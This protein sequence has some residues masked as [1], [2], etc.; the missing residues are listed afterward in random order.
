MSY[1]LH[2]KAFSRK[3]ELGGGFRGV[4]TDNRDKQRY[5]SEVLQTYEEARFFVQDTAHK[6]MKG[7]VYRRCAVNAGTAGKRYEA[8]IYGY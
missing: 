1:T 8:F 6:L 3:P 4:V 5:E 7:Q 2:L